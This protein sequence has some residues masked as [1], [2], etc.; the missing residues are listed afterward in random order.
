MNIGE[1][2]F[3]AWLAAFFWPFLRIGAV[4]LSAPVLNSTQVPMRWRMLLTVLLTLAIA[5]LVK[6]VPIVDPLGLEFVILAG[7][8]ILIGVAMGVM[9]QMVFSAMVFSGQVIAHK[10]GLGFAMMVDPQNGVQVPVVSQYFLIFTTFV[11]LALNGHLILI[12][13]LAR[14]FETL[15]VGASLLREDYRAVVA[16]GSEMFAGGM[17]VALPTVATL[18]LVN[19]GFGVVSRAAPQLHIFAIGFPLAILVG[20]ILIWLSM[21]VTVDGFTDLLDDAFAHMQAILRIGS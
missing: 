18:L 6:D 4:V 5:P 16:W 11:F 15:P 9:L 8:Q 7:Q 2:Q 10:M 17:L 12:E 21:P 13:V 3:Q 14:S 20:Y 1:A 19:L